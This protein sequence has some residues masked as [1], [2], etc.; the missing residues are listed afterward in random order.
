[1]TATPRKNVPRKIPSTGGPKKEMCRKKYE[2]ETAITEK[3]IFTMP[4]MFRGGVISSLRMPI[5]MRTLTVGLAMTFCPVFDLGD[6]SFREC[7]RGAKRS[8]LF[9]PSRYFCWRCP[10]GTQ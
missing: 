8:S 3:R 1:M 10:K 7:E 5:F 2:Y 6:V 9:A 4:V